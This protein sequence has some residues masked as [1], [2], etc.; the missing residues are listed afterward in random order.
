M[1]GKRQQICRMHG[2]AAPR[3][4][5]KRGMVRDANRLDAL[6]QR[7][8]LFQVPGINP[9]CGAQCQPDAVQ[10]DRVALAGLMQDGERRAAA[11]KKVFGM[12]FNKV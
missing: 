4:A 12:D 9:N 6:D 10:A 8:E 7:S 3:A 2:G 5:R 1:K 11:C